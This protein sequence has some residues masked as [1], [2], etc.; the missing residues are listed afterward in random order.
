MLTILIFSNFFSIACSACAP[1]C[2]GLPRGPT[3]VFVA[4]RRG[5][6]VI[7]AFQVMVWAE[8]AELP[9]R[10]ATTPL[11]C[12]DA[13]ALRYLRPDP[14]LYAFAGHPNPFNRS[15]PDSLAY[16]RYCCSLHFSS[17]AARYRSYMLARLG[18][19]STPQIFRSACAS[20]LF[21]I[22]VCLRSSL[23]ATMFRPA[24]ASS[25]SCSAQLLLLLSRSGFPQAEEGDM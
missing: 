12:I 14:C 15:P 19:Y 5:F 21:S 18:V 13:G 23:R 8:A 20:R 2:F 24:H 11:A 17:F 9:T 3:F 16:E 1:R 4:F 7:F 10:R 25:L 6:A 22:L